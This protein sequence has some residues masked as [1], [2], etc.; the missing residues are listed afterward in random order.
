MKLLL[1]SLMMHDN[2]GYV[3]YICPI[4]PQQ[5][6][7]RSISFYHGYFGRCAGNVMF[8]P[9]CCFHITYILPLSSSPFLFSYKTV[10]VKTNK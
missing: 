2:A 6:L 1:A 10:Q 3:V 9:F 8:F 7:A 5:H 4:C